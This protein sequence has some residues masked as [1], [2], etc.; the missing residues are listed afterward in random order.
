MLSQSVTSVLNNS[1]C[2]RNL[3]SLLN[4]R[5]SC[6]RVCGLTVNLLSHSSSSAQNRKH[7]VS[8][9][10]CPTKIS[11]F[12]SHTKQYHTTTNNHGRYGHRL[13]K[14]WEQKEYTTEPL[15]V[16]RTGGRLP[17]ENSKGTF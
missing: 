17:N 15:K 12:E 2:F 6:I 1:K 9:L 14:L 10:S 13:V 8:N 7:F 16:F 11:W 5:Q 3:F 4:E